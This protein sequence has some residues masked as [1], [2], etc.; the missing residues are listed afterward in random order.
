MP[1]AR[2]SRRALQLVTRQAVATA[3]ALAAAVSGPPELRR[4]AML[5]GVPDIIGMYADGSSALAADFYEEERAR[6][7]VHTPFTPVLVVPDRTV[8]IRT[9]VAWASAPWFTEVATS[10]DERLAE[11]VQLEVARAYRD[12]ITTNRKRDPEAV[13]WRRVTNGGCALCR[14]L[15]DRGAVYRQE[16]AR[17]AAHPHC[18]CGA[19]PVFSTNDTGETASAMQYVASQRKRTPK[20]QAALRDYLSAYY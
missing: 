11:V 4:A 2:E 6:A 15:A 18:N 7:Q 9:A 5:E 8:K 19:Q 3:V 1:T 12:T 13:G 17:F 14:M 16:T 20:Q 10:V